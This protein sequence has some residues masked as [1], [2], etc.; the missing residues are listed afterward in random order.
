M[1][2]RGF[3]TLS[4][5]PPGAF[6]PKWSV[7]FLPSFLPSFHP[8]RSDRGISRKAFRTVFPS[9]ISGAGGEDV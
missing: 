5:V 4:G 9:S 7:R 6:S 2:S 1:D 8:D 3:G